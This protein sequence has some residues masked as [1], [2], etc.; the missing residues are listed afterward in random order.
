MIG[1][2]FAA[3]AAGSVIRFFRL[4]AAEAELRRKRLRSLRTWWIIALVVA[5]CLLAGRAGVCLLLATAGIIAFR[6]YATLL[7]AVET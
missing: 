6:E 1:A 7:G 2:V 4:R 3:L 5:G